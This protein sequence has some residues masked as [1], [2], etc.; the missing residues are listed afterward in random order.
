MIRSFR[1]T[2]YGLIATLSGL[3]ATPVF[4]Q[5]IEWVGN[6]HHYYYIDTAATWA[7]ANAFASTEFHKA[8]FVAHLVTIGTAAENTFVASLVAPFS[9]SGTAW[10]GGTVEWPASNPHNAVKRWA[11]G[12]EAGQTFTYS[13]FYGGQA[14]TGIGTTYVTMQAVNVMGF[15]VE[16]GWADENADYLAGFVVEFSPITAVP[17]PGSLALFAIGL[18]GL[19]LRSRLHSRHG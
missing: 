17:E 9:K 10:L 12:P 11:V 19:R 7:E 18:A 1:R 8:G 14:E 6:H 2:M 16:R 15:N 13:N 4:S 5:P 3:A